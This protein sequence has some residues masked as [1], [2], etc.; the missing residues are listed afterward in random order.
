M[1]RRPD[2]AAE[3]GE[4]AFV[5]DGSSDPQGPGFVTGDVGDGVGHGRGGHYRGL[6]FGPGSHRSI[7][8]E[9]RTTRGIS[10]ARRKRIEP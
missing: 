7:A 8:T 6:A 1:R 2:R 5:G 10:A 4:G 9:V 3:V